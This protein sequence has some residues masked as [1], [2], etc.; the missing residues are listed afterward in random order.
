MH[1]AAEFIATW[2]EGSL[3]RVYLASLPN[4]ELR[5]TPEG[6]PNER[7]LLTRSSEQAA[8]FV[9]KWDRI[10]RAVYWGPATLKPDATART[11]ENIQELVALHVDVDF[12]DTVEA[13]EEVA[14]IVEGLSLLPTCLRNTG[15]GLQAFWRYRVPI[16]ATPENIA[17]HERLQRLLADHLAG[18]GAA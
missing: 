14:R 15:H 8:N 16:P 17:E 1:P 6:E 12:K 2:F 4:P 9:A 10:G 3:G 13:P 11:K 5:G 18:D 7:H